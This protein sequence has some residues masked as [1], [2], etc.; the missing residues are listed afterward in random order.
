MLKGRC[1][2]ASVESR[3][4]NKYANVHDASEA[5][6]TLAVGAAALVGVQLHSSENR[7]HGHRN[8]TVHAVDI[9]GTACAILEALD[10][11]VV[12]RFAVGASAACIVVCRKPTNRKTQVG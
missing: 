9:G 2:A 3:S 7:V 8:D 5:P 4:Q 6:S 12:A 10:D 11:G 1:K